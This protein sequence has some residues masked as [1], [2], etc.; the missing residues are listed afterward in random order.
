[1]EVNEIKYQLIKF[2][3]ER[4]SIP[5]D[6]LDFTEEIDLFNYGYVDS[7]GA[8]DLY[9]YVEEEFSIKFSDFD[10]GNIPLN[11]IS[12]ISEFVIKR[13]KGEI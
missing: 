10:L 8:V 1:M 5:E 9:N 13:K 11:T 6:E 4:F 3:R 12:E 7:F 2:L